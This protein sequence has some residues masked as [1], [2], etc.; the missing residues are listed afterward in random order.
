ML[1]P[2]YLRHVE[3]ASFVEAGSQVRLLK[4]EC[5]QLAD[6]L[7]LPDHDGRTAAFRNMAALSGAALALLNVLDGAG[8][9]EEGV[10]RALFGAETESTQTAADNLDKFTRLGLITMVQF[11]VENLI[12]NV[13][14]A[15]GA[16]PVNGYQ[17]VVGQLLA[18]IQWPTANRASRVLLVP[19]VIRNTLHNNG[20]HAGKDLDVQV[21]GVR[22]RIRRGG[23]MGKAG[24]GHVV[25]VLRVQL[26]L[27]EQILHDPAMLSVVH[28]EDRYAQLKSA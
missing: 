14:R 17:A 22:F 9:L 18:I 8:R 1:I 23:R 15:L 20:M 7:G 13:I 26:R 4:R 2:R 10:V 3:P 6:E 21:H 12:S 16:T 25:H 11:Q 5:N 27:L 24:W 28:V 19:A